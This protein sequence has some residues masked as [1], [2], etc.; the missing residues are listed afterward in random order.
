M[1]RTYSTSALH[2][3][4]HLDRPAHAGDGRDALRELQRPLLALRVDEIEAAED[5]LRL[6]E[7]AVG[8]EEAVVLQAYGLRRLRR[9]QLRAAV[10]LGLCRH[11]HVFVVHCSDLGFGDTRPRRRIVEEEDRVLHRSIS[12]TGR[13]SIEPPRR[14]DGIFAAS[15][16]A[17]SAERASTR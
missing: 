4:T 16:S 2:D 17:S 9:L 1:R 12:T 7:R 3:R 15:A 13:T 11:R 8:D 10:A 14:A 5:L 6:R